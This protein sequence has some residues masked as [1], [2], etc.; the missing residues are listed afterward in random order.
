MKLTHIDKTYENKNNTVKALSNINLSFSSYGLTFIIGES[1]CGKTTLLNIIS[2]K[3]LKFTGFIERE[4]HVESIDQNMNLF[5]NLSVYDNL[6][7]VC[8]DKQKIEQL[9]E[10]FQFYERE[11]KVKKL[12]VG[13]KRR[14]QI[15]RSLLTKAS[16]L[17]CDEP[18]ASLDYEN[19]QIVMDMLKEISQTMGVIVVTHDVA[20]VE[21]YSDR[22]I[23]MLKGCIA[24]QDPLIHKECHIDNVYEKRSLLSQL[25]LLIKLMFSRWQENIFRFCLLFSFVF[26]VFIASFLFPSLNAGVD[27]KNKWFNAYNVIV[28]QPQDGNTVLRNP[29]IDLFI[30]TSQYLYYDLYHKEDVDF[31][32]D[33][34]KGVLAYRIGW[35]RDHYNVG[36]TCFV[37]KINIDGLR[38]LV[39]RYKKEYD[40]TQKEPFYFYANYIDE[41]K[42]IDEH[43]PHD[44]FPK[45]KYLWMDFSDLI[46]FK[47]D[48]DVTKINVPT[49]SQIVEIGEN[50]PLE[51]T[52]YQLFSET[53]LDLK[54]GTMPLDDHQ[55]LITE[56]IAQHLCH[57]YELSSIEELIGKEVKITIAYKYSIP[58]VI[59]GVTYMENC[60]E[61][62]VFVIDGAWDSIMAD[63]FELQPDKVAYQY[64]NFL[65]DPTLDSQILAKNIDD[66]LDSHESSF[67]AYHL[68]NMQ[69]HEDYQDP[70]QMILLTAFSCLALITL[71]I[72]MQVLLNKRLHKEINILKHYHY[73]P[74]LIQIMTILLLFMIVMLLQLTFLPSFCHFI[75]QWMNGIII[76]YNIIHYLLSS[77]IAVIIVTILEGSIYAIRTYQHS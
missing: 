19:S 67:V 60:Y 41:L 75:N 15:I 46:G 14:V 12:S 47:E 52:P 59:S 22:T 20:L 74:Y 64:L 7:L 55:I 69:T 43:Y 8:E 2:G 28:S 5:E 71:Y 45:D 38:Q 29:N 44:S 51:V 65:T 54:Y 70:M 27:A 53:V 58:F 24:K 17:V 33:N 3:D 56:K 23:R 30:N 66:L 10:K 25:K 37:E 63:I 50:F 39:D 31:V 57:T 77:I 21:K 62:Q 9:L 6:L 48:S 1:G 11:T 13:E 34:M 36:D 26:I 72:I 35:D 68:S 73:H 40:R 76:E 16:Y 32:H 49:N 61:N 4:G 18:T 42:Y